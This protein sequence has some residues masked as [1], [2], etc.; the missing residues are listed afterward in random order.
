VT[1][2]DN[3]TAADDANPIVPVGGQGRKDIQLHGA[4]RAADILLVSA[5]VALWRHASSKRVIGRSIGFDGRMTS[6]GLAL[7]K[8]CQAIWA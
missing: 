1:L 2:I 5:S 6:P 7:I 8:A 4:G 3:E